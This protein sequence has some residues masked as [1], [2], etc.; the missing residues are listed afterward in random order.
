[1]GQLSSQ[2]VVMVANQRYSRG[3]DQ[4][5]HILNCLIRMWVDFTLT[6]GLISIPA[7]AARTTESMND[8]FTMTLL[9]LLN[10]CSNMENSCFSTFICQARESISWSYMSSILW[11]AK[12]KG[13]STIM[14][15]SKVPYINWE[16]G[17][18]AYLML[19]RRYVVTAFTHFPNHGSSVRVWA[20]S[21]DNDFTLLDTLGTVCIRQIWSLTQFHSLSS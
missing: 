17:D 13:L 4:E 11:R 5:G 14:L 7:R 12:H 2:K 1:M 8:V 21:Y 15:K 3:K 16:N 19:V 9:G 20:P 18:P 10:N 6:F